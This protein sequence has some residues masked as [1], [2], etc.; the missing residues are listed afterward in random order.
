M[1]EPARPVEG[2]S[3]AD[4][5]A[6]QAARAVAQDRP[7][8]VVVFYRHEGEK[9][10]FLEAVRQGLRERGLHSRTYD[11]AHN[12]EHGAGKLYGLLAQGGADTIHLVA[13]LARGEDGGFDRAFLGYLNLHRDTINRQ[14]L[15][16]VL[17]VHDSE[18]D[19]FLHTAGDLWDFRQR[20][21]WLERP[22]E[23]RGESLWQEVID[24]AARLPRSDDKRHEIEGHVAEV[25]AQANHTSDPGD[26]AG[27]LLDLTGWLLRHGAAAAAEEAAREALQV[28]P[29]T[30][31]DLRLNIEIACAMA[32]RRQE[33]N[34]E[35]LRHLERALKL[36]REIGDRAGEAVILSNI[37]VIYRAWGHYDEA[38]HLLQQSLQI[39]DEIDDRAGKS[40][41]LNNI[42]L[43]YDAWGRY[44]EALHHLQQSLQI[45]RE[46]GDRDGE[47]ITL[48]NISGIYHAWERYDESLQHL[49]QSLQISR[50]IGDR[51]G[52]AITLNNISQIYDAWGRH[53]EALQLLQQSLQI[54]REIGDRAGEAVTLNNISQIYEA[55]GRYD[56][57]LQLL[58]RSLQIRREIGDRAGEAVTLWNLGREYERRDELGSAVEYMKTSVE[59]E[60]KLG[61]PDAAAR[62]EQLAVLEARL[63]LDVAITAAKSNRAGG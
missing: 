42:S 56:Q 22:V 46:I 19:V 43:I 27:L 59:L 9:L 63:R 40:T 31:A 37:A 47:A 11:P 25:H 2:T 50:E 52:E 21:I 6:E 18:A 45:Q 1:A 16:L 12:P 28:S 24:R 60:A 29:E 15:R 36:S 20:T 26:R 61:H 10:E 57:V 51:A 35:A 8:F 39:Q 49:Q 5:L 41:T 30:D 14:R 17:F 32:L 34:P 44:D 55:W 3:V 4:Q 53:N 38:L 23:P 33:Q 54:R 58:Q 48:C 7:F 62:R 13:D